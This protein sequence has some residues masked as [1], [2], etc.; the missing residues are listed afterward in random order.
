M[1]MK[2]KKMERVLGE[3]NEG[4]DGGQEKKTTSESQEDL[5]SKTKPVD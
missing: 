1:V 5:S 2:K 4:L 3:N